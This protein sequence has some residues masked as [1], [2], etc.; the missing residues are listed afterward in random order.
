MSN[1][2]QNPLTVTGSGEDSQKPQME[3]YIISFNEDCGHNSM[4]PKLAKLGNRHIVTLDNSSLK[5]SLLSYIFDKL[6]E[7]WCDRP[8]YISYDTRPQVVSLER[9]T[10]NGS[11]LI[12]PVRIDLLKLFNVTDLHIAYVLDESKVEGFYPED[13]D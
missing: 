5:D 1:N 12:F 6:S 13:E 8:Y 3:N 4:W 10:E 9:V 2:N 7:H 11:E